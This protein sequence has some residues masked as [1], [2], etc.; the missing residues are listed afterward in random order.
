MWHV[1]FKTCYF[2]K[3]YINFFYI[4]K[5]QHLSESTRNYMFLFF[6][7][8]QISIVVNLRLAAISTTWWGVETGQICV[9]YQECMELTH[10]H[11]RLWHGVMEM[12]L[13]WRKNSNWTIQSKIAQSCPSNQDAVCCAHLLSEQA[14]RPPSCR[15]TRFANLLIETCAKCDWG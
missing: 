5:Y 11:T 15:Q 4:L 3:F 1:Y 14:C 7:M 10:T 2:C 6:V 12:L 9:M 8:A 13:S